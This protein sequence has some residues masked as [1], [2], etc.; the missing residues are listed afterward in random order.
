MFLSR[1]NPF[2]SD[3]VFSPKVFRSVMISSNFSSNVILDLN[4]YIYGR[5]SSLV[6][7]W[8][9]SPSFVHLYIFSFIQIYFTISFLVMY[10]R[11]S[12]SCTTIIWSSEEITYR[13]YYRAKEYPCNRI[14]FSIASVLVL[15]R[16]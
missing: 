15:S 4:I 14:F 6:H 11:Y 9:R 2:I 10:S 13:E 7:Y 1:N 3:L 16:P 12:L 5:R 8:E